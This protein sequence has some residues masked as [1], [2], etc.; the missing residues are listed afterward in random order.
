MIHDWPAATAAQASGFPLIQTRPVSLPGDITIGGIA[1]AAESSPHGGPRPVV[2]AIH[3]GGY[4]SRY[5]D[6]SG[7]SLLAAASRRGIFALAVDRPCY[8]ASGSLPDNE[9]TI[10]RNA[11]VLSTALG[12]FWNNHD[13][14]AKSGAK[15]IVLIGHSIGA[16]VALTMA[17]DEQDWPLLGVAVS[18]I[19]AVAG[20][21]IEA[22][23]RDMPATSRVAIPPDIKRQ[24]FFGP[25][26]SFDQ[27][28]ARASMDA[29]RDIPR[30][31]LIDVVTGWPKRFA[32]VAARIA[33][34]VQAYH[35]EFETLWRMDEKLATDFMARF[36]RAPFVEGGLFRSVGHCIDHH[37]LGPALHARQLAFA[38]QCCFPLSERASTK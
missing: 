12:V 35:A 6:V 13:L 26:W 21:G 23:W 15:G 4:D 3:G 11:A 33:V 30:A 9:A 5:F 16:A 14:A 38:L 10:E 2:V 37:Y 34:P 22:A 32:S 27:D 28:I 1:A 19:G 36:T 20:Q 25:E 29:N 8:G 7:Y 31:E 17:S 24:A 18:G